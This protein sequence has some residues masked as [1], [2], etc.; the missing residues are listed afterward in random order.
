[1]DLETEIIAGN[2]RNIYVVNSR[3]LPEHTSIP[4]KVIPSKYFVWPTISLERQG[5]SELIDPAFHSI[6]RVARV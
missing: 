1:M 4:S 6:P 3:S 2:S 5:T